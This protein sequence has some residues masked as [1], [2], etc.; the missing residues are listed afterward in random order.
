MKPL[1]SVAAFGLLPVPPMSNTP[2][3]GDIDHRAETEGGSTSGLAWLPPNATQR[4]EMQD[5]LAPA[6]CELRIAM[7]RR[8]R[9][10]LPARSHIVRALKSQADAM[11]L[12]YLWLLAVTASSGVIGSAS[13]M[14]ADLSV[15]THL[16]GI[17]GLALYGTIMMQA[18]YGLAHRWR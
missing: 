3:L 12:W 1:T 4:L 6:R 7:L 16:L 13:W 11:P 2:D 17:A 15:V 18:V 9:A 5:E 8:A 10:S 14:V